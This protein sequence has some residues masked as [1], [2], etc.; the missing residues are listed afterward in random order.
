MT[1]KRRLW[2]II[3]EC[4]TDC[5]PIPWFDSVF[6]IF[7]MTPYVRVLLAALWEIDLKDFW[8]SVGSIK[9]LI[10]VSSHWRVIGS[11]KKLAARV[12]SIIG[13]RVGGRGGVVGSHGS[14]PILVF[15][16]LPMATWIPVFKR[17]LPNRNEFHPYEGFVPLFAEKISPSLKYLAFRSRK[18]MLWGLCIIF[19]T[20]FASKAWLNKCRSRKPIPPVFLMS[21]A[22]S[23]QPKIFS[24]FP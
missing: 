5:F 20:W 11:I 10:L 7:S 9:L 14:S 4:C 21:P 6:T 3:S 15:S 18:I 1:R 17:S 23:K 8:W 22:S 16:P 19:H 2:V 24:V 12:G 13:S